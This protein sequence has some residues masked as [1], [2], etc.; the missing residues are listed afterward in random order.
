MSG[1]SFDPPELLDVDV[2]QLA[3]AI[4]LV[5]LRGLKTDPPELAH[6]NPCQDPRDRRD[7]HLQTL[8]DLRAGHPQ[9]PQ[10]RDH[11]DPPL[12][13]AIG[14]HRRRRG[15]IQQPVHTFGAMAGQ[16]LAR[17]AVTDSGR[18]GS[19]RQRPPRILD[20]LDEELPTFDA[21]LG[22]TVQL[23]PVSSLGLRWL[24]SPQP[25]RSAGWL[26]HRRNNVLRIYT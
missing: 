15:A 25:P 5:A 20:T 10:S 3:W 9:P 17:A 4:S 11:L 16:P 1:A 19:L 13:G 2:Q 23:H 26:A 22:V 21:E 6:P 24:G 18:L 12:I 7:R 8:S 14:H